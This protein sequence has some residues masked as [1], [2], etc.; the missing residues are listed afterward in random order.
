[1]KESFEIALLRC[2]MS[3]Q[4]SEG[5]HL[6][7]G[8]ARCRRVYHCSPTWLCTWESDGE[9]QR[10][11]ACQF[12]ALLPKYTIPDR[13]RFHQTLSPHPIRD[14]DNATPYLN[15]KN[16]GIQLKSTWRSGHWKAFALRYFVGF[17]KFLWFCHMFA[18][19]G[20]KMSVTR[21]GSN[22]TNLSV[23]DLPTMIQ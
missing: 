8:R 22:M 6:L 9:G 10:N 7:V 4:S 14:G 15:R 5:K 19:R 20:K 23:R 13:K 2:E 1:M 16:E 12:F 11:W 17:R 21:D 18:C 3:A